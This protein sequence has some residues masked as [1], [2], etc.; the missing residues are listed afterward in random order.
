MDVI[1]V[2][3]FGAFGVKC[4]VVVHFYGQRG[5][6][7]GDIGDDGGV[8]VIRFYF[9]RLPVGEVDPFAVVKALRGSQKKVQERRRGEVSAGQPG[10]E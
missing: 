1:D 7:L 10:P 2:Y 9:Q 6:W 5:L 4:H 3:V 8:E